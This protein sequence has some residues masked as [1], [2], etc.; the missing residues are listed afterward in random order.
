MTPLHRRPETPSQ[1]RVTPGLLGEVGDS[2]RHVSALILLGQ[3]GDLPGD[4]IRRMI[5]QETE[6]IDE[7]SLT[8][9][10]QQERG[11]GEVRLLEQRQQ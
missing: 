1:R 6:E 11:E 2:E 3:P 5:D 9:Y 7:G 4:R 8:Q 10:R